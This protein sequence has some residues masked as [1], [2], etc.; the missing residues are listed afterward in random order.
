VAHHESDPS[1]HDGGQGGKSDQI[2]FDVA[3]VLIGQLADYQAENTTAD[4]GPEADVCR[5][6]LRKE[7]GESN[8]IM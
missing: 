8:T 2:L 5:N 4:H 1:E 6:G 3:R 7:K